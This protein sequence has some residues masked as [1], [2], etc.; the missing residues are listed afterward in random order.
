MQYL[1]PNDRNDFEVGATND[2]NTTPALL[3][4]SI[5]NGSGN[6]VMPLHTTEC[7]QN[8]INNGMDFFDSI[9]QEK[10]YFLGR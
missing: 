4:Y 1:L 2:L 9:A 5:G 8:D 6:E 3:N 7:E 10:H